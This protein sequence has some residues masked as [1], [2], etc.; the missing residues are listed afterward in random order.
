MTRYNIIGT[1]FI[2]TYQDGQSFKRENQH[3]RFADISLGRSVEFSI[4]A[5]ESNRRMLGFGDDPSEYGDMLRV[6]HEC[7]CVYDGGAI[8]GTLA[9]TGYTGGEFSCVFYI[10]DAGWAA[11]LDG[12]KLS[13]F[14]DI[15][16]KGVLWSANSV[17]NDANTAGLEEQGEAIVR[18]E[19]GNPSPWQ[20]L[21][22]I[23]IG[24]YLNDMLA[25]VGVPFSTDLD[26]RYWLVM[27]TLNG[28]GTDDV[29]FTQTAANVATVSQ[30]QGYFTV[31]D[32]TL[33]YATAFVFG[34]YVG[35]GSVAAKGYKA[36][37]D[38]EVT[39]P[40]TLTQQC[41]LVAWDTRL[42]R[43]SVLGGGPS[44]PLAGKT[45]AIKEGQI[46]FFAD[47]PFWSGTYYGWKDTMHPL[48]VACKVARSEDM[49]L[50][51]VWYLRNNQPDMT[52]FDFLKSVALATGRELT[53]TDEGVTLAFGTYGTDF[54]VVDKV[55]SVEE[56]SRCVD[57]WGS[58]TRKASIV[59]DSEEYVEQ[60]IEQAYE[61][62]NAN[63]D[64]DKESKV[65]FSE[66]GV[67]T[68]GILIKDAEATSSTPKLVAKRPTI[69][70]AASGSTYL[71]RVDKP[72]PVGYDDVSANSTCLRLRM[73]SGEDAFFAL[74]PSTT[75]L[76]RGMAYLWT[77]AEWSD[78]ILTLTLQ[79]VSQRPVQES[80]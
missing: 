32:I 61:I 53:V 65:G 49:S 9:V 18:Y 5:T 26:K 14:P 11:T 24:T 39:M 28:G 25:A 73:L 77:D 74:K 6:K 31:E 79:K 57:A 33:E 38:V 37:Q 50:G 55:V 75:W 59:F 22:A 63:L 10:A 34:L 45:I 19:N 60:P 71:Q 1:G 44:D 43:C 56:V 48:T 20:L 76:W 58:G 66:G 12:M 41:W 36:T 51:E 72:L 68:Y 67:G 13:E 7:Q 52:I 4:P 42:G 8:M 78:G 30:S 27:S 64:D 21:P 29:T 54:A 3:F 23:N 40:S 46:V 62:D 15:W 2:E 80:E 70:Y 16:P 17:V 47:T 69:S 35:G